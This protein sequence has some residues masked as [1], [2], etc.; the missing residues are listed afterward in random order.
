MGEHADAHFDGRRA[1]LAR[2]V[3]AERA[4]LGSAALIAQAAGHRRAAH[5]CPPSSSSPTSRSATSTSAPRSRTPPVA[6]MT[7]PAGGASR[8]RSASTPRC[9]AP[10]RRIRGRR[11]SASVSWPRKNAA[12]RSPWTTRSARPDREVAD[13]PASSGAVVAEACQR[14]PTWCESGSARRRPRWRRARARRR[15][16]A[17]RG[18]RPDTSRGPPCAGDRLVDVAELQTDAPTCRRARRRRSRTRRGPAAAC[19]RSTSIASGRLRPCGRVRRTCQ[20]QRARRRTSSHDPRAE[21]VHA[22][23]RHVAVARDLDAQLRDLIDHVAPRCAL[24]E[25]AR[26][27]ARRSRARAAFG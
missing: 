17:S 18:A 12:S 10:R 2:D 24:R 1:A 26:A 15:A 19:P 20:Q 5:R 7:T 6:A 22:R 13:D 8:G 16:Q 11:R 4:D 3:V 23:R 25:H 21:L 14:S 9:S 27:R